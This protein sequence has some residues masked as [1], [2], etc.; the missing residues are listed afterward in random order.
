VSKKDVV[1][2][3]IEVLMHEYLRTDELQVDCDGD[4]PVR[5]HSAVYTVRLAP[6]D[7][8]CQ[9]HVEV[10]AV[11]VSDVDADPG[12]YEALNAINRKLSHAR[13]FW[14]ERKVIIAGELV[15]T[16]LDLP[17]LGCV[18]DEVSMAA[19]MEGPTLAKTFGG[20]VGCP[21]G[22]GEEDE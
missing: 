3:H 16:S 1:Q 17:A 19:H 12:L 6:R 18:C 22:I 14:A 2:S 21:E 13:A 4:I 11:V 10:Y 15:G 5:Y 8:S 9:P 7:N 20:R